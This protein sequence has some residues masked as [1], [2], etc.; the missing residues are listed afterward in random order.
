[1]GSCKSM[2]ML[3]GFPPL[4]WPTVPEAVADWRQRNG[5]HA[6]EQSRMTFSN[7]S[8]TCASWGEGSRNVTLCKVGGEGHAWPGACSWP[9]SMLPGMHC[10]FDIDGSF[11]AM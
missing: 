2:A 8:A 11:H 5:L 7:G 3:P 6:D 1:M 9:A 4:P 10:S